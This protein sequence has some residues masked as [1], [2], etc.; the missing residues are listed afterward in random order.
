MSSSSIS[1]NGQLILDAY[2]WLVSS[3]K[4]T[5]IRTENELISHVQAFMKFKGFK[6][7]QIQKKPQEM[8][9]FKQAILKANNAYS[10]ITVAQALRTDPN[11]K[12]LKDVELKSFLSS[13]R[14]RV[15]IS[16][17]FDQQVAKDRV[18][19]SPGIGQIELFGS[20][21]DRIQLETAAFSVGVKL[22]QQIVDPD[23]ETFFFPG[24]YELYKLKNNPRLAQ[25][26][27]ESLYEFISNEYPL[28]LSLFN[29]KQEIAEILQKVDCEDLI[30]TLL[31]QHQQSFTLRKKF[32][33][34][35][36]ILKVAM[37]SPKDLVE[38]SR[39][40]KPDRVLGVF[41]QRALIK[42][43]FSGFSHDELE[44]IR[45]NQQSPNL[46][47]RKTLLGLR[48]SGVC[49]YTS[50][51][52]LNASRMTPSQ[53]QIWNNRQD[54]VSDSRKIV[55]QLIEEMFKVDQ[56]LVF[57]NVNQEIQPSIANRDSM[58]V[59]DQFKK[60]G[61]RYG[62]L[63]LASKDDPTAIDFPGKNTAEETKPFLLEKL[64]SFATSESGFDPFLFA[65]L[66][67]SIC[68]N[69]EKLSTSLALQ[70]ELHAIYGE[71]G[72]EGLLMINFSKECLALNKI[73]EDRFVVTH[74][75]SLKIQNTDDGELSKLRI[76]YQYP[77]SKV[78]NQWVI[79]QPDRK[80]IGSEK[81][82]IEKSLHSMPLAQLP[83]LPDD[84]I[85]V[86]KGRKMARD[87][88]FV[89]AGSFGDD[90]E[91][92]MAKGEMVPP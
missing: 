26:S 64:R 11:L 15:K 22:A 43:V 74:E 76:Q 78:A 5:S 55:H 10:L 36:L 52:P 87:L 91:K 19:L 42:A 27:S 41:E 80:F 39:Q 33:S 86:E 90:D 31:D 51:N 29:N 92:S 13:E 7:R 20:E 81:D 58:N 69:L 75:Y 23:D 37:E 3:A 35:E 17:V 45:S 4:P 59:T 62:R 79:G 2:E 16:Q 73:E 32:K 63:I 50:L 18:L 9:V 12:Q 54:I 30:S 61:H 67:E 40:L 88:E 14:V 49:L 48:L 77:I 56:V 70:K 89:S 1:L 68:Q 71:T 34:L 66:Q 24:L 8:E 72:F 65:L 44:S 46:E 60:D 6:D 84:V 57:P 47:K 83:S 82:R 28:V 38:A 25:T 53:V 21:W 85:G